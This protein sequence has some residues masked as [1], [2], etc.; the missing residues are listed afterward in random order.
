MEPPFIP[1]LKNLEDVGNFQKEKLEWE[2]DE[3][4]AP[5]QKIDN[6]HNELQNKEAIEELTKKEN[7]INFLR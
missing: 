2:E 6:A 5:T 3:F 7:D 1:E 4:I